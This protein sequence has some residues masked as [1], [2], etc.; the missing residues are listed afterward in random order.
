MGKI[1]KNYT[2][3]AQIESLEGLYEPPRSF[4]AK[5]KSFVK[6]CCDQ[7]GDLQALPLYIRSSKLVMKKAKQ[8]FSSFENHS[9]CLVF[10][11]FVFLLF[12]LREG[13]NLTICNEIVLFSR[14]SLVKL[15]FYRLDRPWTYAV[16]YFPCVGNISIWKQSPSQ[17]ER[18]LWSICFHNYWGR[19]LP[20]LF[21][22]GWT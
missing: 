16:V 9:T 18:H 10:I 5:W 22:G 6:P 3:G 12:F 4:K 17:G 8:G 21:L 7:R 14:Q 19:K 13:K 15:N 1:R 2:N 20:C 11:V